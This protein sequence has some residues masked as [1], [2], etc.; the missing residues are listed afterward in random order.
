MLLSISANFKKQ[1]KVS[2]VKFHAKR[3]GIKKWSLRFSSIHHKEF[4]QESSKLIDSQNPESQYVVH[5]VSR[6]QDQSEDYDITQEMKDCI[7]IVEPGDPINSTNIEDLSNATQTPARHLKP[8]KKRDFYPC[9]CISYKESHPLDQIEC[10]ILEYALMG[11]TKKQVKEFSNKTFCSS[12]RE[13]LDQPEYKNLKRNCLLVGWIKQASKDSSSSREYIRSADLADK[14]LDDVYDNLVYLPS[15]CDDRSGPAGTGD[16]EDLLDSPK[17]I[18]HNHNLLDGI[19]SLTI[20]MPL[21]RAQTKLNSPEKIPAISEPVETESCHLSLPSVEFDGTS[22]KGSTSNPNRRQKSELMES[23]SADKSYHT[24]PRQHLYPDS[25]RETYSQPR[26]DNL[27]GQE[28][29]QR[30]NSKGNSLGTS[31][32]LCHSDSS[33]YWDDKI[34]H[35]HLDFSLPYCETDVCPDDKLELIDSRHSL[36]APSGTRWS[37]TNISK[38]KEILLASNLIERLAIL[39]QKEQK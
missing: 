11:K 28:G 7:C 13:R 6:G 31:L 30:L 15:L 3:R 36:L 23:N 10:E 34:L 24:D 29:E 8:S 37:S 17:R 33:G 18:V 12:I 32:N 25:D 26:T 21:A 16:S 22:A 35:S 9:P 4:C 2:V 38:D 14:S 39:K 20:E 5:Y 27:R 19:K 1:K